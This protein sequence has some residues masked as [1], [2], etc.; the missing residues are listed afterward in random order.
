MKHLVDRDKFRKAIRK[1]PDKQIYR[2]FSDAIDMLP[3]SK[4]ERLANGYLDLAQIRSAGEKLLTLLEDAKAFKKA[5]LRGEYYESFDVNW[6]NS[7]QLSKG[8]Q[9]WIAEFERLLDRCIEQAK[10]DRDAETLEAFEI[11]FSLLRRMDEGM[12]DILFFADE[13]GSWEVGIDWGKVLPAWSACLSR[14]AGPE[15]Y[16]RRV[17]GVIDELIGYGRDKHIA[18]AK[19]MA[20]PAQRKALG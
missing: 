9:A 3:P 10:R 14:A 7:N 16:A 6:K 11:C 12:D 19:R 5:S 1:L 15:E 18:A 8:T 2:M 17:L 20:T 13:G 4:L